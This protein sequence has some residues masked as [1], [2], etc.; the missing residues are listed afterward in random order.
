MKRGNSPGKTSYA[1]AVA[2]F[3]KAIDQ[4]PPPELLKPRLH[5]CEQYLL[6]TAADTAERR[7]RIDHR[8]SRYRGDDGSDAETNREEPRPR[9][10][11][12][13]PG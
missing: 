10:A 7:R 6:P 8:G 11:H 12:G 3:I 5:L 4:R 9:A 13:R 1:S 2:W